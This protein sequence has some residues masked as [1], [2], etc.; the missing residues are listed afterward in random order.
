MMRRIASLS[1][2]IVLFAIPVAYAQQRIMRIAIPE[3][4]ENFAAVPAMQNLLSQA[5]ARLNVSVEWVPLPLARSEALLAAGLIDGEV[6]R[7]VDNPQLAGKVVRVDM[8]LMELATAVFAIDPDIKVNDVNGLSC[9]RVGINR[10]F[11]VSERLAHSAKT[12]E[13]AETIADLVKMLKGGRVDVI[14]GLHPSGTAPMR[15]LADSADPQILVVKD[16]LVKLPGYHYIA[17]KDADLSAPLAKVLR[18]I[19]AGH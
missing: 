14:L 1:L 3:R 7:L 17:A 18:E 13:R 16:E 6:V 11:R 2:L 12:I 8:P 9:C 4:T 10:N 15:A 19:K 5:Y